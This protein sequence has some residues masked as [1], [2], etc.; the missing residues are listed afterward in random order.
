M[1]FFRSWLTVCWRRIFKIGF[2]GLVPVGDAVMSR[3]RVSVKELGQVDYQGWLYRKK[4]GK[5]FLGTKWKKY[6]FV[7]KKNSLYW[8]PAKMA[9]K[10]EGYVNLA[11]FTVNQA[12]ECKKKHALKASHPNVVTLY[13]AAENL[14]EMNIWLSKLS[15][16]EVT[17]TPSKLSVKNYGECYSEASDQE[18]VETLETSCPL[19]SEQ[20][21][22]DSINGDVPPPRSASSPCHCPVSA[23]ASIMTSETMD[24]SWLNVCS[25]EK[26]GRQSPSL[27]HL[28]QEEE[29]GL[30]SKAREGTQDHSTVVE[31]DERRPCRYVSVSSDHILTVSL[32]LAVSSDHILT[33]SLFL[34]VSTDHILTFSLFLSVSTDHILTVSLF[35]FVSTDHILTVSL[36]LSVSTDHI[37]TVSLFLSVSTDHILT[38]SLFLSVSTDH[39]LTVSLFLS[40][41]T[42]HILTVSLFLSVSTDH[43]LTVSLS[44]ICTFAGEW[45]SQSLQI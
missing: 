26:A 33:V 37:L 11:D 25:P 15:M 19:Y 5:G 16:V 12:T 23:P 8:Y 41:S 42:D 22:T 32:F 10:A 36:F 38:V 30:G 27:L 17:D 44:C 1:H 45:P 24:S 13:F 4:E 35:L 3:R 31:L 14:W 29:D 43:I 40:V 9:E 20:L 21:T 6:W 39:I 7:L 18:E 28:S 34:S 2:G